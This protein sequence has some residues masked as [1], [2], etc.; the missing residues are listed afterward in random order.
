MGGALFDRHLKIVCHSHREDWQFEVRDIPLQVVSQYPEL[1]K[2]RAYRLRVVDQGGDRHQAPELQ[3]FTA[4]DQAT[5]LDDLVGVAASFLAFTGDVDLE[6]DR[7]GGVSPSALLLEGGDQAFPIDTLD[8]AEQR[9]CQ[10]DL[11]RLE[12]PN[13]MEDD[14]AGHVLRE[15]GGCAL[16]TVLAEM[17]KTKRIGVLDSGPIDSLRHS[18]K[19]HI[20]AGPP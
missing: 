7:D 4:G 17:T 2:H 12:L 11:I 16:D 1:S 13:Q 6:E 10:P 15:Y 19:R 3:M 20:I 8:D 18:D 5:Q 9:R 14:I